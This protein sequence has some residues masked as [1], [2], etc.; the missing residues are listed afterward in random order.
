MNEEVAR[1]WEEE[2]V[3]WDWVW[4]VVEVDC[5]FLGERGER[6]IWSARGGRCAREGGDGIAER[7]GR[8]REA[9]NK[10]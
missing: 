8:G 10:A 9:G 1:R 2:L 6:E 7:E 4:M 5:W 3:E